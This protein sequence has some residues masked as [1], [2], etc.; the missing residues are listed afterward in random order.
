M[1][2]RSDN[3]PNGL[4]R[5][6]DGSIGLIICPKCQREN[7]ALNVA[8]GYWVAARTIGRFIMK[9]SYGKKRT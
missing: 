9:R 4:Y 8:L 6:D 1:G 5:D 3:L 7:Y 2:T